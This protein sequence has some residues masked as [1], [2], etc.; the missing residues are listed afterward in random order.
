MKHEK[1]TTKA[2][3][4]PSPRPRRTA[5]KL[6]L[7]AIGLAAIA[8]A[9]AFIVPGPSGPAGPAAPGTIMAH[10]SRGGPVTIADTCTHYTGA[11]VTIQAPR[12]G[13]VVVSATVGVGINHV[14]GTS[15]EARIALATSTS[16]CA[17]NNFTAFVSVPP[18]L[19]DDPFHF[20]TVPLLR[21][22]PVSGP[23]AVTVYV[24]GVMAL[25]AGTGDRFD[26]AS[27][28]AVYY[29]S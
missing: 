10:A 1:S 22:F 6:S 26:S 9:L 29:P 3:E 12:A 24:N 23:G 16:D 2:E 8:I 14:L 13:T 25:G 27:L 17:L 19:M 5:R 4:R 11:E 28:V 18:S 21:P 20:E 7:I 15:D